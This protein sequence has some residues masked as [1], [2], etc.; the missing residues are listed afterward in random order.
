VLSAVATSAGGTAAAGLRV[1]A[2]HHLA[3]IVVAVTAACLAV[4][5]AL[6]LPA[7][8]PQ[9]GSPHPLH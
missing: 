5:A 6:A 9:P 4:L 1:A 2:G 3:F 7:V 8:R